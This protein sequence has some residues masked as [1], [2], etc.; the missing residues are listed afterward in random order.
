[1][2]WPRA[3]FINYFHR[4]SGLRNSLTEIDTF[5]VEALILHFRFNTNIRF[6]QG[7]NKVK[8]PWV[9]KPDCT[10]TNLLIFLQD[11]GGLILGIES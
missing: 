10:S 5:L 3:A 1:M 6:R 9:A 4:I 8:P 2:S 7:R 11:K